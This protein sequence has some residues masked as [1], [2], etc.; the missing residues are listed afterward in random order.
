VSPP[1]YRRRA[2]TVARST[3]KKM[4]KELVNRFR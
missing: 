4:R 1:S 3:V 2:D